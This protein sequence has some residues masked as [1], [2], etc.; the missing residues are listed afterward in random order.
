MEKIMH[1]SCRCFVSSSLSVTP[2][3]KD[4]FFIH[5]T[6]ISFGLWFYSRGW[7]DT[8]EGCWNK[9]FLKEEIMQVVSFGCS[10]Y[11]VGFGCALMCKLH[12]V[13]LNIHLLNCIIVTTSIRHVSPLTSWRQLLLFCQPTDA[14]GT[15]SVWQWESERFGAAEWIHALKQQ[16]KTLWGLFLC[17]HENWKKYHGW[18][19]K[20][21]R[22][23]TETWIHNMSLVCLMW[24]PSAVRVPMLNVVMCYSGS[25]VVV[26]VR[27]V[28]TTCNRS[29]QTAMAK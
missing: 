3:T 25:V 1:V 10:H 22:D 18:T 11:P 8:D 17:Y 20:L 5:S 27:S 14:T 6:Y 9:S 13:H 12:K 7:I 29:W 24:L 15:E 16:H 28:S 21:W 2:F 26:V 4:H 19:L 23:K